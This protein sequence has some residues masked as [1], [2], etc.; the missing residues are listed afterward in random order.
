MPQTL[1]PDVVRDQTIHKLSRDETAHAAASAMADHHISAIVIV[2]ENDSIIGI[3]TERDLARRVV[4]KNLLASEIPIR[5]IMTP[6]PH[7]IEPDATPYQALESMR[8]MHCRHLPIAS[9]GHVVGMVSIRD[10]RMHVA[11][12]STQRTGFE[13]LLGRLGIARG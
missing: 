6:N 11:R 5:D 13:R 9:E 10:L 7:T 8:A 4:A 3:V 12:Q 2:D 1:I